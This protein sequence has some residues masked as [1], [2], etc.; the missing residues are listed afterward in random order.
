MTR[1]IDGAA[2]LMG[3]PVLD[4]IVIAAERWFSF[5]REGML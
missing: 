1:D 2:R 4:H 5:R 3:I